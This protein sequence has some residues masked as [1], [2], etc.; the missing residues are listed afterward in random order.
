MK[1]PY[2]L[3]LSEC[4][5]VPGEGLWQGPGRPWS[6][7][8]PF[9]AQSQSPKVTAGP[10]PAVLPYTALAAHPRLPVRLPT[11]VLGLIPSQGAKTPKVFVLS[12]L[13]TCWKPPCGQTLAPL[14]LFHPVPAPSVPATSMF[15]SCSAGRQAVPYLPGWVVIS[16]TSQTPHPAAQHIL[17]R[18]HGWE[19]RR[20]RKVQE[21]PFLLLGRL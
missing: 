17:P 14:H 15:H 2:Q 12:P 20:W 8:S 18:S 13:P 3:R 10:C 5:A 9:W 21:A 19:P 6:N 11:A 7:A 4:P 16:N 1:A